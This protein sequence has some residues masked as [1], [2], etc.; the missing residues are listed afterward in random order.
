MST[1][2]VVLVTGVHGVSGRAAAERWSTIPGTQV[3]GLS[4]RSAP[5]PK[6]V[7]EI[8]GDLLDPGGLQRA[9]GKIRGV[10]HVV[11]G[12]YVEKSTAAARSEVNV[13]IIKNL[14]DVVETTSPSLRHITFYQGGKAYGADLGAFKTPAREDDPRL[15][16]PNFYYDQ[17]DFLRTRQQGKSWHWTALRPEA[18][19]GFGVGNPMNLGMSIAVYATISKELGL[20]LRFPGTEKSYRVLYS[21]TSGE[22]LAK[23]TAW[24]GQSEA[25]RNEIFN[26]TNGDCFRW[27]YRASRP[28]LTC[29]RPS[30]SRH[31]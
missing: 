25:A 2:N 24:A 8:T 21:I 22:I 7:E 16:P 23:A 28:C 18:T 5:L 19:V 12:A 31:R 1:K 30:R 6:G 17:E 4:R 29:R 15:M 14:L 13:A 9:L 26:I 11:F 3:F 20:P 10:T 27:R